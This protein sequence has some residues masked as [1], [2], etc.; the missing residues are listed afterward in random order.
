MGKDKTSAGF[1]NIPDDLLSRKDLAV[2]DKVL[3]ARLYRYAGKSDIAFPKQTR[4][5]TDLG[6][7]QRA[8]SEG[9]K[10]LERAKMI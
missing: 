10:R 7:T 4:L 5:A 6:T 2:L 9:L 1:T 8:I 3:Y